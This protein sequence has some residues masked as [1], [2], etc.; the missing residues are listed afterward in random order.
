MSGFHHRIF[1]LIVL[2][3]TVGVRILKKSL[4]EVKIKTIAQ[5]FSLYES[6]AIVFILFFV[7]R[8]NI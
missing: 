6:T 4:D 5:Q 7:F 1:H 3:Y 2:E 8:F